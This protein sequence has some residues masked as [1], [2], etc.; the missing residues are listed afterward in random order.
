MSTDKNQK[1]TASQ[2]ETRVQH[3][4]TMLREDFAKYK[5]PSETM[6]ANLERGRTDNAEE[7][8]EAIIEKNR[9]KSPS[10]ST[11][12]QLDSSKGMFGNKP[13]NEKTSAGNEP[14]LEKQRLTG[15][16]NPVMEKE[17]YEKA[18]K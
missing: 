6:Q 18:N 2:V 5:T 13:R 16:K 17:K 4:E 10:E 1:R 12:G 9:S 3:I 11:E 8:L 7:T 14:M 15:K